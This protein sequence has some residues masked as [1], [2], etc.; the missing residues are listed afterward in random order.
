MNKVVNGIVEMG[1]YIFLTK[2]N[3]IFGIAGPSSAAMEMAISSLL[4]KGRKVLVLNPGVFR[5]RFIEIARGIDAD[6]TELLPEPLKS[7][8][9]EAVKVELSKI[10]MISSL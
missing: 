5:A 6:V 8:S 3:K 2:N 7:F 10:V 4:W 1:R 9:Q